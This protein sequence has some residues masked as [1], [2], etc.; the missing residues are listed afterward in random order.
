MDQGRF[1]GTASAALNASPGLLVLH[2]GSDGLKG[3]ANLP[4]KSS[5]IQTQ[6]ILSIALATECACWQ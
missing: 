4:I 6:V 5:A 2:F 1:L 3:R